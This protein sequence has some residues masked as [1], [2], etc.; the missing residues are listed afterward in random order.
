MLKRA[1]RL[2]GVSKSR[3]LTKLSLKGYPKSHKIRYDPGNGLCNT[4]W[5]DGI[6]ERP[7]APEAGTR[8][9][10][11]VGDD[12]DYFLVPT[13]LFARVL[14]PSSALFAWRGA[15][16]WEGKGGTTYKYIKL[17]E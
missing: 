4:V 5:I 16:E 1:G 17:L 3:L 13:F 8:G 2:R 11:F 15:G 9:P 14:S 12:S 10:M 7:A 6:Q